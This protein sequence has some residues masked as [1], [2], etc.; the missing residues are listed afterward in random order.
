MQA[1]RI[2]LIALTAIYGIWALFF[3]FFKAPFLADYYYMPFLGLIAATVANTT[4]AAA[5]IVYFPI[6]TRLQTP[7]ETAAQF[8]LMIQAFGMGIGTIRWFF[9]NKRLFLLSILPFCLSGGIIGITFSI[10][11]MPIQHPEVLTLT[12]N[13]VAFIFTQFIFVSILAK[14]PYPKTHIQMSTGNRVL[15]FTVGL[16][17]GVI[18]GWI[19]FG[20]DTI[21]YFLL[22]L[23][24]RINPAIAIVTSISIMA[25]ISI[26]GAVLHVCVHTVPL[27]LWYAAIPGVTLAGLFLAAWFAI[28]L[29]VRNILLMFT[30]F[31]TIDFFMAFWTQQALPLS[32]VTPTPPS[33]VTTPPGSSERQRR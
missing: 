23:V 25:V 13:A 20:I 27:T 16:L 10:L 24:F 11:V 31:L 32:A 7:P 3:P 19:G 22:T 29:G 9:V 12:F 33:P 4:P 26:F 1:N 28:R 21:F 15:F 14:R 8:S 18:S 5:G 6:L 30:S 2:Q 17:G